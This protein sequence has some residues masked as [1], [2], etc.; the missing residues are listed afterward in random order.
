[1]SDKCNYVVILCLIFSCLSCMQMHEK[2]SIKHVEPTVLVDT[3]NGKLP[4]WELSENLSTDFFSEEV[5][6]ISFIPLETNDSVLVGQVSGIF[7]LGDRLLI[8]D[9]NKA[10]R[11]FVFDMQG[12]YQYSIGSKGEGPGQYAS[13]NQVRVDKDTINVFDWM[14]WKYICYDIE[15]NVLYEH[16]FHKKMPEVLI[17]LENQTFVGAYA[18]YYEKYPFHLSWINECDSIVDTG[19]PI[20]NP[21]PVP[22]GTLQYT[23]DGTLLFYHSLCDTIYEISKRRIIPKYSLGLYKEG[24]VNAFLSRTKHMGKGEYLKTLFDSRDGDITNYFSL[25]E[26]PDAW[27]VEHQKGPFVY[28]S[29]VGKDGQTRNYIR[30]DMNSRK[31]YIPFSMMDV[32]GNWLLSYIDENFQMKIGEDNRSLFL[33]QL[34]SEEDR[35]LLNNYDAETQNPIICMFHLKHKQ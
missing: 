35:S 19:L 17:R 27:L 28:F 14:K 24:E 1:M 10:Q 34:V 29:V 11:I 7:Y 4:Q 9:A 12:K 2:N 23:L 21:H 8:V 6:S 15:G 18:G 5:D 31:L 26:T 25:F 20:R 30:T 3:V 32:K 33:N 13:L 22:A 16:A